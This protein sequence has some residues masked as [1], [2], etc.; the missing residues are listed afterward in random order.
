[1]KVVAL[2]SGGKDS[3][4]AMMEAVRF[5]HEV[6]CLAHLTP[7]PELSPEASEIDS[8]MYQS[9]GHNVVALIAEAM[10]LPLVTG[11]ITGSA[12]TTDIDYRV[13]IDGDEV[14]DLFRL[15]EDVLV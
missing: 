10:E 9:V 11:T 4:Y 3:C 14:E 7:P 12:I 8:F 6:V 1:M 13:T 15:L 5:G 2:V